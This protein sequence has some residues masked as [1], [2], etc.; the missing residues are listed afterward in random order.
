MNEIFPP[1]Y[2]SMHYDNKFNEEV[3]GILE[4]YAGS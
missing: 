4:K 3:D 1:E 2:Y